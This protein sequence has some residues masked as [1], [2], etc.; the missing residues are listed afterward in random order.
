MVLWKL[1]SCP[2]CGG[3]LFVDRDLNNSYEQCLQCCYRHEMKPANDT[4]LNLARTAELE[5][6]RQQRE[7]GRP[8]VIN[9]PEFQVRYKAVLE[10]IMGGSLSRRRAAR[11]LGVGYGTLK[12]LLDNE[13]SLQ[14]QSA[15]N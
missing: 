13:Q 1:K 5:K 2:R 8:R 15:N 6:M 3:D 7:V 11:E 10:R 14:S 9:N 4:P 12:K